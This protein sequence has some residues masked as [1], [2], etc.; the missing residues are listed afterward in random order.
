M[1]QNIK[2][3]IEQHL[4]DYIAKKK[5]KGTR[6]K[7]AKMLGGKYFYL[8]PL[9]YFY[10]VENSNVS[11]Q[12]YKI[13]VA[14]LLR[15]PI[16]NEEFIWYTYWFFNLKTKKWKFGGQTSLMQAKDRMLSFIKKTIDRWRQ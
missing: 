14:I 8:I 3:T 1:N 16:N 15:N 5:E 12:I 13:A 11:N 9:D 7:A 6:F 10:Q 4:D 2:Q